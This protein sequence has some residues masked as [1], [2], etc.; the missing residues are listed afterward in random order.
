MERLGH[1]AIVIGGSIA[2]LIAARVLSDYFECVTILERDEIENRPAVHKS[3]PQGYHLHGLLNGGQ[4][5]LSALYPGFTDDLRGLGA[6]RVTVGRDIA[7]Y[8]PDG[9]SYSATGS[10]RAPF[11]VGLEA[12]CASRGLIEYVIR[13][14]THELPGIRVE[15]GTV[16]ELICHDSR[17]SGVR[18]DDARLF[19]AELVVDATGRASRAPQWLAAAGFSEPRQTTIGV[20]TAYSTANFRVPDWYDG[21]TLIF[22]TG[23]A[24]TFTRRCYVIR[25]ENG[26]LLVSLIGR[27]GDYPPTDREGYLAFAKDL[28]SDLAWRIIT[29]AE[30]LTP[31]AHHRFPTSVQRHYEQLTSPAERFLAIGDA[32]CTF[33]PIH[34]QG[35]SAA[36]RQANLLRE[37]LSEH[38]S[39]ARGLDG[40]GR[41]FFAKAAELNSTPWNLA[42]AFDFAFPQTRGE[43]PPGI[44]ERARYF[45][46]LDRLQTEDKE[47]RQL[48]TEVFQ[49]VRPLST[50]LEEPLRSRVL[51]RM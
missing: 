6:H 8:L 49:L 9:K 42:A 46:A 33:N 15:T 25:I 24:P 19:E 32:L 18:C 13:R 21:E 16:R 44:E 27:F 3:V 34:A 11:D 7:W 43:R 45:A 51:A 31:I 36:A 47:I 35:M 28:H 12:H 14:R 20:D 41:A 1:D 48:M 2:G 17:I 30:Q 50:L 29:D 26:S 10:L 22:I 4:R 40:I 37:V 38:Q 39:Q 23:P 5:V